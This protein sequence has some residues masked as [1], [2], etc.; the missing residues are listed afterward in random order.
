MA[1]KNGITTEEVYVY[2][3]NHP[4][5]SL[6]EIAEAI[7]LPSRANAR[8]H[9]LKLANEGRV[10]FTQRKHRNSRAIFTH[11]QP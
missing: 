5:C 11:R 3:Y 6:E 7:N 1:K 8:Y 9:I 10:E 2:L 4:G